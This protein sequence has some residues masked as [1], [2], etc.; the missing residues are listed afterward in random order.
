MNR[1]VIITTGTRTKAQNIAKQ[2]QDDRVVF[3]DSMPVP[4]PLLNSG[5][6]IQLPSLSAPHFIH[7]LL[8]ACLNHSADLV[9]LLSEE[10][11]QLVLPQK[12]LFEEYNIDIIC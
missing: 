4:T 10:E 8:K 9:V 2:Y 5:K 7:E 12:I 1:T 6:F 3:A 11:I